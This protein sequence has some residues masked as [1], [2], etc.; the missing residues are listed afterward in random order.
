MCSVVA[1]VIL[2]LTGK[3]EVSSPSKIKEVS[4]SKLTWFENFFFRFD[5]FHFNLVV[6]SIQV[7]HL[8]VEQLAF[9]LH[10]IVKF[11]TE[12]D[13]NI[14][15]K[16][17]LFENDVKQFGTREDRNCQGTIISDENRPLANNDR[18][19]NTEKS[20]PFSKKALGFW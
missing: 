18:V 13:W 6:S 9:A 5:S 17:L 2:L 10:F 20:L 11:T 15:T 7:Y 3:V 14:N 12:N 1:V 8:R 4:Y 16:D 19:L